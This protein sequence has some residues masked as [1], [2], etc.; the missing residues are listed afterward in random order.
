[1][2]TNCN[3][4]SERPSWQ[5]IHPNHVVFK[6]FKYHTYMLRWAWWCMNKIGAIIIIIFFLVGKS[7]NINVQCSCLHRLDNHVQLECIVSCR[8]ININISTLSKYIAKKC[9]QKYE[10]D[11]NPVTH[12]IWIKIN[13]YVYNSKK[14]KTGFMTLQCQWRK[15]IPPT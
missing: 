2:G 15:E 7:C 5:K 6:K 13:P 3:K 10:C 1:M 11:K 4:S 8:T 9:L 12:T 14:N